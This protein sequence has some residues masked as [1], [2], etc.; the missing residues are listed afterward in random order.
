MLRVAPYAAIQFT[1]HEQLKHWFD[2]RTYEKKLQKPFL[3]FLA[4]SIAGFS[5]LTCTY[6]LDVVRAR[7]ATDNSYTSIYDVLKRAVLSKDV[8]Y[9][10]YRGLTPALLG[11]V[12]YTGASFF[13]YELF[14]T[15]YFAQAANSKDRLSLAIEK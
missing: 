9:S 2:I 14:K 11:V 1:V 12:P 10:L 4:G 5:A 8:K 6:P 7:L 3:S 15:R 13:I